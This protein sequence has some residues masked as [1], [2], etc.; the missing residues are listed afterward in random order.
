[1]KTIF[2][3]LVPAIGFLV[4][5]YLAHGADFYWSDGRQIPLTVDSTKITILFESGFF[6]DSSASILSKYERIDSL[7]EGP[8]IIDDFQVY[9]LNTSSYYAEFIDSLLNEP[10]ILMV[11]PYYMISSDHKMLVGRTFACK[12]GTDVS[13]QIID[14]INEVNHVEVV[15]EKSY[16]PK[17][18]LL[19]LQDDATAATLEIANAYYEMAETD[20]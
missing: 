13:Y 8:D 10:T 3:L 6:P 1:M 15:Y 11:N 19:S 5:P 16:A 18:Y 9:A 14:S 2:L 12:F 4:V 7:I 20:F 17:E